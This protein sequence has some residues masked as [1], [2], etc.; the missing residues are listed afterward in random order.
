MVAKFI[1]DHVGSNLF[2]S[3]LWLTF[4]PSLCFTKYLH[5][6]VIF[7][8]EINVD[9]NLQ[10]EFVMPNAN[11]LCSNQKDNCKGMLVCALL[12]IDLV[13]L[14]MSYERTTLEDL[15]LESM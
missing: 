14:P 9:D 2:N 8:M 6:V 7:Y 12:M 10:L 1:F 5:E 11:I 13:T 4:V 15:Y 3:L